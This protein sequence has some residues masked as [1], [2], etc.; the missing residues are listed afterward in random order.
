MVD[1]S[2][3]TNFCTNCYYLIEASGGM[4]SSGTV[5]TS[6]IKSPVSLPNNRIVRETLAPKTNI[7]YAFKMS[8]PLTI[9]IDIL[10]GK[11]AVEVTH[12]H[13]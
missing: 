11:A 3:K 10:Y 8:P 9:T 1:S 2:N 6:G 13:D 5:L 7:T 12:T 4:T